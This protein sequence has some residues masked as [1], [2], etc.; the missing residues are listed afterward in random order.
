MDAQGVKTIPNNEVQEASRARKIAFRAVAIVVAIFTLTLHIFGLM[1]VVL[2][3]LPVE[4]IA[5]FV[6]DS[7]S[8]TSD[9]ELAA[10]IAEFNSHRSHFMTIGIVSWAVVITVFAQLRR[11]ERRVAQLSLIVAITALGA[12]VYGL[13]GTTQEWLIEEVAVVVVPFGLLTLLHPRVRSLFTRPVLDRKMAVVA[14]VAAMPWLVYLFDNVASQ[15]LN[16]STDPHA[17]VDWLVYSA[18]NSSRGGSD[19]KSVRWCSECGY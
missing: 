1:E 6:G 9:A 18:A 7:A 12:I 3:W 17:D 10:E 2:M 19:G 16:A 15:A 11:P 5:A 14:S 8:G 13:S 4:I